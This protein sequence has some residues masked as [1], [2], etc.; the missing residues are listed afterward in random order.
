[1]AP[2]GEQ[3]LGLGVEDGADAL[4]A[5]LEDAIGGARGVDDLR[6]IG[7]EVDHRLF[8]VDVLARVHG[9]DGSLLVPVIGRGDED[10]VDVLAGED[11]AVV[12]GG[13][14]VR[15]PQLLRVGEAAVV[16]IG[17]GDELDAG[18][19]QGE[20]RVALA[21]DAGADQGKLDVVVRRSRRRRCCLGEERVEPSGCGGKSCR[22]GC[23]LEKRSAI[24]HLR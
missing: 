22:F 15:A 20:A 1:M 7:V 4:A 5:D 19:L 9:V 12:A 2:D 24:G 23:G 14:E 11:L 13:E 10:G 18:N 21:L 17:D 16:A 8:E 3:L 6:P